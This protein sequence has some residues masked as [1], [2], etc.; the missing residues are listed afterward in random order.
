MVSKAKFDFYERVIITKCTHEDRDCVGITGNIIG[1]AEEE[2]KWSYAV[3]LVDEETTR[4]FAEG[5]MKSTGIVD[6]R[7]QFY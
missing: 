1:K 7:D 5:E 2:G 6:S 4:F 3:Q